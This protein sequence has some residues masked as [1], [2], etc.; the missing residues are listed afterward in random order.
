MYNMQTLNTIALQVSRNLHI[1]IRE[2]LTHII[3]DARH[4][5][6]TPTIPFQLSHEDSDVHSTQIYRKTFKKKRNRFLEMF[7]YIIMDAESNETTPA[8]AFPPLYEDIY[9]YVCVCMY[10]LHI[11]DKITFQV[12][13]NVH[14]LIK[15]TSTHIIM[16]TEHNETTHKFNCSS[17]VKILMFTAHICQEKHKKIH[18]V[19]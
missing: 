12:S 11:L 9:M 17:L 3:I 13:R 16:D 18:I 10:N 7:I 8:I 4:D 2:T 6:T 5:E 15:D 19:E 1:L 14:I